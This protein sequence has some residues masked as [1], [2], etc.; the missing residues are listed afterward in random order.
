MGGATISFLNMVKGLKLKGVS[1]IVAMPL[2]K[3]GEDF[4]K[5]LINQKIEYHRIYLVP[6]R[7][8]KMKISNFIRWIIKYVYLPIQKKKSKK[9]L[10]NLVANL[11]P[12][13]I[14]TNVGCIHE[15]FWV[16][17][18]MRIPHIWHIR[19]YQTKDFN[20]FIYPSFNKFTNYLKKSNIITITDDLRFFF[21]LESYKNAQTIYN[22]IFYTTDCC[23]ESKKEPYFLM[24]SRVSSE[25]GHADAI[26]AFSM[27]S[28]RNRYKLLIAGYGKESYLKE[29]QEIAQENGCSDRIEFMGF[30]KDVKPL[31]KK[32]KALIVS[33]YNEGFGRMTAEAMFCGTMVIGR[34]TAGTKEIINKT[35][36]LFFNSI[37][38]LTAQMEAVDIISNEEYYR[39]VGIAQEKAVNLFSI[40]ANILKVQSLYKDL[41][42]EKEEV[43]TKKPF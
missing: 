32:A 17:R 39:M 16:S 18:R 9:E 7:I 25:K 1:P 29:L 30:Q 11:K 8:Q 15:G 21:R 13:I 34:E 23:M 19:E 43:E 41:L 38:E 40:E 27:F 31:M 26:K 36:G 3:S 2:R 12:D 33:S 10:W 4:E 28:Q 24:A 14:H 22:G 42:K 20:W 5:E 37:E 6:S 35:G